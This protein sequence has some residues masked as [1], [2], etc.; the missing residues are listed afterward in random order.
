MTESAAR[1]QGILQDDD[2]DDDV[3]FVSML[4][5]ER[6]CLARGNPDTVYL[7]PADR[8]K[9]RKQH[10]SDKTFFLKKI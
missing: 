9:T 7:A 3:G 10:E 4:G 8:R 2:D 1:V 5:V 6:N